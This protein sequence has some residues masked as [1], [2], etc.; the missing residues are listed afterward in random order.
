MYLN[1]YEYFILC[2]SQLHSELS[3]NIEYI[4]AG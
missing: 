4:S 3:A 1:D 2:L